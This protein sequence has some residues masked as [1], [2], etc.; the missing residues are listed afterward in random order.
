AQQRELPF[1][2]SRPCGEIGTAADELHPSVVARA[3]VL[4][5][6]TAER[7]QQLRA[8]AL[9]REKQGIDQ[10]GD[11]RNVAALQQLSRCRMALPVLL[12]HQLPYESVA[13]FERRRGGPKGEQRDRQR[14]E[15]ERADGDPHASIWRRERAGAGTAHDAAPLSRPHTKVPANIRRSSSSML[16]GW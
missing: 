9:R 8:G 10:R 5:G 13:L 4:A 14:G 3:G 7:F 2:V 11:E 15:Q 6:E 16:P 1:H 12:G